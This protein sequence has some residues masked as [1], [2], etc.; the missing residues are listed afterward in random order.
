MDLAKSSPSTTTSTGIAGDY[1]VF[2]QLSFTGT[3]VTCSNCNT[4]APRTVNA[5]TELYKIKDGLSNTVLLSEQAGRPTYY[6]GR[7]AQASNSSMTNPKFWGCWASYQSVQAQGWNAALP[8]AAG[9]IYTMNRSNSQGVYSFHDGGTNFG[10][11]DGSV[12]F[13]SEEID[14][15]IMMALYTCDG[16]ETIETF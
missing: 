3:G 15:K 1:I 4:A 13:I 7:Q 16:G 12:R 2:H 11:C 14:I 10:L 6:I 8:P 5:I 9:G